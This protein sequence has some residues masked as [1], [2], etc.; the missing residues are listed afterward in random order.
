MKKIVFYGKDT[1]KEGTDER[2]KEW[3]GGASNR[4]LLLSWTGL[5]FI[6]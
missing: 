6:L 2:K 1:V 5:F 4:K 3:E